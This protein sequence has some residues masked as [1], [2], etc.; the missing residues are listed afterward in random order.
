VRL[1]LQADYFAGVWADHGQKKFQFI[2]S[3]DVES[4]IQSANALGDDRLQKRA[5]GFT[6][7]EKYPHG[8]SEQRVRWFRQG[9]Q[10]GDLSMMKKI[11][12]ILYQEL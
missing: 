8:T 11:F 9:L 2:E 10:T 5:K 4:A 12:E 1:E 7:P 6:S 3:G